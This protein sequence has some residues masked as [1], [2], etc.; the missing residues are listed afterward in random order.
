MR[1]QS[2]LVKSLFKT[3]LLGDSLLLM[4]IMKFGFL[5]LALV[6]FHYFTFLSPSKC[7]F[8]DNQRIP[9][10]DM[11]WDKPLGQVS[12]TEAQNPPSEAA[13]AILLTFFSFYSPFYYLH[14][15][16][17]SIESISSSFPSTNR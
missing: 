17:F 11:N 10:V 8:N 12:L 4:F 1:I 13:R 14:H 16:H 3:F 9:N 2:L 7:L 5:I 15:H 6:S